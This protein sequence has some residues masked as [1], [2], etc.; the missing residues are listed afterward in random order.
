MKTNLNPGALI[1]PLP[2][3]LIS[4]GNNE[5]EYNVFT[6]SWMGTLSSNPPSCYISIKPERHSHKIIKRN[7]EFAINLT[8]V[9]LMHQVDYCG[10]TTGKDKNKFEDLGLTMDFGKVISAPTI[11]ESPVSIEC[12]VK[13]IM[14]LG[15]HDMFIAD[16]VNVRVD[17]DLLEK[18]T[19]RLLLD[20]VDLMAF[21]YGQYY[22][23]GEIIGKYG[24]SSINRKFI[25]NY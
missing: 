24:V 15:S 3:A 5:A 14:N 4:C 11:V 21:S 6:V 12:R 18:D 17:E 16:I 25:N 7:M 8:T 10:M 20:K 13:S 19:R 2:V 9:S 1:Y 23:L 22:S